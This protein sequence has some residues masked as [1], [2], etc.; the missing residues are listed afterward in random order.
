MP[1]AFNWAIFSTDRLF[2]SKNLGGS[3]LLLV[4]LDMLLL[5]VDSLELEP[6]SESLLPLLLVLPLLE[7]STAGDN[8]IPKYD[9]QSQSLKR[10]I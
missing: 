5:V 6:L 3:S 9:N 2:K 7:S 4:A 8:D 1:I 10:E